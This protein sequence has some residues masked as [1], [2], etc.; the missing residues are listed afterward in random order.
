[1]RSKITATK[2]C[3]KHLASAYIVPLTCPVLVN[4]SLQCRI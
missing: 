2:I 1:L 4:K 3:F